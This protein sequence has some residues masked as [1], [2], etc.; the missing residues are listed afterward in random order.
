M[1]AVLASYGCALALDH[2]EHLGLG[3]VVLAVVLA[4]TLSRTYDVRS[5]REWLL[6]LAVLCVLAV[7][8]SEVGWLLLRHADIGDALFVLAVSSS[9]WIRRFGPTSARVGTI[10]A[11]PFVALLVAPA[12]PGAGHEHLLWAAVVGAIAYAWVGVM[13]AV[14]QRAG[15]VGPA[16]PR[17][18]RPPSR[19]RSTARSGSKARGAMVASTKMALQMGVGLGLAFASGRAMFGSHWSWP[20]LTAFIVAS[21]NRGRGDVIYKSVLRVGGAA[22]GTIAATLL[23]GALPRGSAVDVVAIFVV[24][25]VSS[26]LRPF[27]YGYWAAGVTGA[28]ALLYGYFGE[29]GPHFLGQRLEGIV[30]GA[31]IAIAVAWVLLPIR[32]SDV[33]RRRIADLLASLGEVL[34]APT[35]DRAEL[36]RRAA[37]YGAAMAALEEVA[38]PLEVHR[39]LTRRRSRTQAPHVADA[40]EAARRCREPVAAIIDLAGT[41][42]ETLAAEALADGRARVASQVVQARRALAGRSGDADPGGL[43][44]IA[45]AADGLQGTLEAAHGTPEAALAEIEAA[46]TSIAAAY[47]TTR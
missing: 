18:H 21:G 5:W 1:A 30:V 11:L 16:A 6:G 7:A 23:A 27:G 14:G 41:E 32:S 40:I 26:W 22:A 20:V 37:R 4:L 35:A 31:A 25:G 13:R 29:N 34:A 39:E 45:G 38:K 24:L 19:G 28:V 17:R 44:A 36:A 2:A 46:V 9:I 15:V 43:P 10:V 8:A 3:V 47:C 12:V 42:P 33:L